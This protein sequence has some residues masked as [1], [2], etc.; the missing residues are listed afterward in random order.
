MSDLSDQITEDLKTAMREKNAVVLNTVRLLKSVI[1][2]AAIE[3]GGADAE[4]D[5]GEIAGIIRK[6]VKKRLD[7]IEQ[8]ENAGREDLASKEKEELEILRNYLPSQLSEEEILELVDE[9][10]AEV[11]ATSKKEMGP[12]MKRLQER[13]AGRADGRTLSQAV[14]KKLG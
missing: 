1:K 10:I 9:G 13:A 6:E 5:D 8:F 2:N 3:K 11:G 12:V 14:M 7:S 4:L